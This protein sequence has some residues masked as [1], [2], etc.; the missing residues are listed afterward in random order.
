MFKKVIAFHPSYNEEVKDELKGLKVPTL[1]QWVKEDQ[2]HVWKKK[3][4][5]LAAK[6]PKATIEAFSISKFK[7]EYSA[8]SYEKFSDQITAPLV[9][10]LTGVDY[11]NPAQEV[12]QAKKEKGVNTK[13]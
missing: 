13:G 10:F 3:W 7:S 1:I 5:L 12:F 6:I 9:K 2:F 8:C 11:L 4:E